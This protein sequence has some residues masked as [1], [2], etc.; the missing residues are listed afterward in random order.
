MLVVRDKYLFEGFDSYSEANSSDQDLVGFESRVRWGVPLLNDDS[1]DEGD[2][3]GLGY[4]DEE[5]QPEAGARR[6]RKPKT[7]TFY[8]QSEKKVK[9]KKSKQIRNNM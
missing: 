1:D 9:P 8:A 7:T 2:E 4:Q 3:D 6:G 5:E